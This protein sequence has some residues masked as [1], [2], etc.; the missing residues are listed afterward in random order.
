MT[1]QISILQE[2]MNREIEDFFVINVI[3][4]T[5]EILEWGSRRVL[6]A[7]DKIFVHLCWIARPRVS[8]HQELN[9]FGIRVKA[10]RIHN[11]KIKY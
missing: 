9:E 5:V 6:K 11:C 1:L 7:K 2:I 4:D 10:V 3:S 8:R